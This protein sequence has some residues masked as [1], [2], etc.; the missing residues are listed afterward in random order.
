MKFVEKER[1]MH[2]KVKWNKALE[3]VGRRKKAHPRIL[4]CKNKVLYLQAETEETL[5][6]SYLKSKSRMLGL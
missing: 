6:V 5:L 1:R 2:S 4:K 3:R